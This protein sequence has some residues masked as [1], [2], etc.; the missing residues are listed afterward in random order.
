MSDAEIEQQVREMTFL[1]YV[2]ALQRMTVDPK[3][4]MW[5]QRTGK[6][7]G[8][9]GPIDIINGAGQYVGSINGKMPDAISPT[10][11]AAY[12][13]KDDMDVEKVVVRRLPQSW[14]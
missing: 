13:E 4:R 14:M 5:I 3:G 12:I 1:D 11:R 2:P 6:N 8:A 9:D 10:G 7:V